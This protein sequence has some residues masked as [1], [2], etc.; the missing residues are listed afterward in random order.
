M[1]R[2]LGIL[3]IVTLA[4]TCVAIARAEEAD[5]SWNH[6]LENKYYTEIGYDIAVNSCGNTPCVTGVTRSYDFP[7][8]AGAFD[9]THNSYLEDDVFVTKFNSTGSELIYSTFLGGWND[10]VGHSIAMDDSGNVYVTGETWGGNFPVT[11][12]AYD[13]SYNTGVDAFVAKLN[14]TGNSLCYST[15]LG[16]DNNDRG[17]SIDIDE[18]GNAYVTGIT[19]SGD[20]PTTSGAFDRIFNGGSAGGG[21]IFVTKINPSGS[22]LEYST[23][24]GG[25]QDDY[26]RGIAADNIG[27]IYV[28]GHTKSPD[29]PV[30]AEAF[31]TTYHGDHDIIMV[32][33]DSAGS[34]LEYSTYLGG[35]G[36]DRGD[37]IVVDRFGQAHVTGS[38]AS[39]DFTTTQGV[40]DPDHNG[41]TDVI[42]FKLSTT[43]KSLIYST[44]IGGQN[45]DDG[46][47]ITLDAGGYSYVTGYTRSSDFPTTEGAFDTTHNGGDNVFVCKLTPSGRALSYSTF[48]GRHSRGLGVDIDQ[49]NQAYVTGHATSS[50]F[51]T[52]PGA[53][54]ETLGGWDDVFVTK[55]D[56]TG[57][58]LVFSTFLGSDWI[59]TEVQELPLT[60]VPN[61]FALHQ[62]YPNPFNASTEIRYQLPQD[63]YVTLRIFNTLGQQVRTLADG[64]QKAGESSVTWDGRD[65]G[66]REVSSG[67][68]FCRLK[69]GDSSKTIKMMLVR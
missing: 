54:D 40:F 57:S 39:D 7:T 45:K 13:V 18:Y 2:A 60:H 67:I 21:D 32:C 43:G 37:D 6:F 5:S 31:D 44:F 23:F 28:T 27:R 47:S 49:Y 46:K 53:F 24:I 35:S 33:I 64:A 22:D 25:Q 11:D 69:A 52:T 50:Y 30:T 3:M 51:P 9:E 41:S 55:F 10:D 4:S 48:L 8:T 63:G 20:F 34:I 26:G 65:D 19:T 36:Y 66:D 62:N 17:Y 42:L 61:T 56:V 59:D 68:Y 14:S 12:S 15:F 1:K 38:S 29:F 16:G 58:S